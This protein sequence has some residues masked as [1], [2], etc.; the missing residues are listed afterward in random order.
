[1]PVGR[2]ERFAAERDYGSLRLVGSGQAARLPAGVP[3]GGVRGVHAGRTAGAFAPYGGARAR[4]GDRR[5]R[6]RRR[7]RPRFGGEPAG[8]RRGRRRLVSP[9]ERSPLRLIGGSRFSHRSRVNLVSNLR[10]SDPMNAHDAQRTRSSSRALRLVA[11]RVR[12]LERRPTTRPRP[13]RLEPIDRPVA[14]T[15]PTA[16]PRPVG[17]RSPRTPPPSG[18]GS[19]ALSPP[20]S[21]AGDCRCDVWT[22]RTCRGSRDKA[23]SRASRTGSARAQRC[24][25]DRSQ[26]KVRHGRDDDRGAR[27]GVS[28]RTASV[29]ENTYG[30][31]RAGLRRQRGTSARTRPMLANG[32]SRRRAG[33]WE[34]CVD[35]AHARLS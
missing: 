32:R 22:T 15:G 10:R 11:R 27:P 3:A 21:A 34:A 8:R 23:C 14:T 7:T 9:P 31:V 1:V 18:E 25:R 35:G 29:A 24:R 33:S 4:P 6:W 28:R 20:I 16:A 5:E 26:R 19:V 13:P 30:L 17:S 2:R 12:R